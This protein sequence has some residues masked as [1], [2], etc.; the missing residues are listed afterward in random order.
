[1]KM[2]M[3]VVRRFPLDNCIQRVPEPEV[4]HNC[5]Q[6]VPEPEVQHKY[7]YMSL[8]DTTVVQY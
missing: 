6:R 1:M 2:L 5:I 7:T 3:F 4:Q 8:A